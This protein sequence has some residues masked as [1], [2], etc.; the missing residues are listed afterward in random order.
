MEKIQYTIRNVPAQVDRTLRRKA[1]EQKTSLNSVLLAALSRE[2]GE[3]GAVAHHDLDH[4]AGKW[5]EDPD[6]DAALGAQDQVD[7]ELWR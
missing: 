6:C 1:S 4:L 5:V 2:A 3:G 7:G